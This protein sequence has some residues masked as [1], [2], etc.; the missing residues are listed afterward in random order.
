MSK[1]GSKVGSGIGTRGAESLLSGLAYLGG[2]R[3]LVV[4]LNLIAT[5]HLAQGFG[6]N[7]F[8]LSYTT[9]F[10]MIVNL[11]FEAYVCREVAF[12]ATR[13]RP[14]AE[15][16][17]T[18]RLA[19]AVGA[20]LAFAATLPLLHLS[21][22][23]TAVFAIQGVNIV[24]S[25]VALTSIYQGMRRMSVVAMRE[26]QG[27]ALNVAGV[28]L[29]VHGP[30][31]VIRA[32]A[33]SA[34]TLLLSNVTI[35][36][37]FVRDYGALRVRLPNRADLRHALASLE[38]F[39]TLLAVTVTYNMH[40]VLLGLLRS[41]TDVGLFSA[42]WKIFNFAVVAPNLISAI[43]LPRIANSSS[44]LA[45]RAE[46]A[47]TL[48][49]S[50][51]MCGVP[52]ALIGAALGPQIL[53][54]IFGAGYRAATVTLDLLLLNAL[55]VTFNFGF[56]TSLTAVGRNKVMFQNM[57]AGAALGLPLTAA[58]IPR[59]GPVGAAVGTLADEALILVLSAARRPEVSIGRTLD[60]SARC[61]AASVPAVLAV[62]AV[63]RA[64]LLGP[65]PL[66]QLVVGGAAGGLAYLGTL[67]ALRVNV[68]RFATGLRDLR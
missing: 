16:M 63:I 1:I 42:G 37:R 26:L 51:V 24:G 32:A 34:G 64:P 65:S 56:T 61:F 22:A 21:A 8:A 19:L 67:W 66:A 11:G 55:V 9:Y 54:V 12:D 18:T 17:L 68:V 29:L 59:F 39:W 36:G 27:A 2:G 15:S 25:S 47:D 4:C 23:G 20:T 41:T 5:S 28:L 40:M 45:D 13:L 10:A 43:F 50:V 44:R 35:F 49:R 6:I 58:L 38:Y 60:F 14:Y 48:M 7:S 52:T 57:V 62:E 46:L 30:H 31:D 53:L 33:V 3:A